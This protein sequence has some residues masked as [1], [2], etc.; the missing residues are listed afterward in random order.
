M[1]VIMPGSY[2][3]VTLGHLDVIRRVAAEE[4]E[5]YAVVFNNPEKQYAFSIED[6]ARMLSLATEGLDNVLVS[7]STGR[8]VDYM[9]DHGIDEIVKGYRNESDLAWEELQ[10][11]YNLKNGGY[12]TRLIP[13]APALSEVSSTAVRAALMLG[14]DTSGLLPPAVDEYVKEIL[15]I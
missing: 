15:N 2:D 3:P 4:S 12:P 5:V 10:A 1:S 6:R 7:Y 8:V 13:S 14:E 11:E 9:R